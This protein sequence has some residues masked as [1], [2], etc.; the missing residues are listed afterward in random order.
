MVL[1]FAETTTA[2][3]APGIDVEVHELE[4]SGSV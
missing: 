1:P 3:G 2:V 4:S